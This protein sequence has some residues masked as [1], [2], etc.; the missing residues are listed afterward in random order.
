MGSEVFNKLTDLNHFYEKVTMIVVIILLIQ[1]KTT[2]TVAKTT[3]TGMLPYQPLIFRHHFLVVV[4]RHL[5]HHLSRHWKMGARQ[6][7]EVSPKNN[8]NNNNN[9]NIKFII[10]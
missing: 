9:N 2:T 7:M 5:P 3:T 8:N 4:A 1:I 6:S 10:K